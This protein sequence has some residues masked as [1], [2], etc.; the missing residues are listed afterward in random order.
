MTESTIKQEILS[1]LDDL[2]EERQRRVLDFTRSLSGKEAAGVPGRN[3]LRFG[4]SIAQEDVAA[5]NQAIVRD[6]E[7]VTPDE[8]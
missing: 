1:R 5:M 2:S 6:C 7:R 8:W 3:L 4:G